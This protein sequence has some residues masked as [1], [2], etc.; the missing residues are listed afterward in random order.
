MHF[1]FLTN[2]H[3]FHDYEIK[4]DATEAQ[5]RSNKASP[6]REPRPEPG[7]P[8]GCLRARPSSGWATDRWPK[9][10]LASTNWHEGLTDASWPTDAPGRL[11][12]KDS[13]WEGRKGVPP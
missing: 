3:H 6:A 10:G 2:K 13:Q 5:A 4:A 8:R 7:E 12:H 9:R 1:F 11:V